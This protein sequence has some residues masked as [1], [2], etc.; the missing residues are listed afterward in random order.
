MPGPGDQCAA[1]IRKI[2]RAGLNACAA[3]VKA[4]KPN[5]NTERDLAAIRKAA[6][7]GYKTAGVLLGVHH[8]TIYK[9]V[10]TYAGVADEILRKGDQH[11]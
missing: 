7:H 6:T 10:R 5:A 11:A 2:S 8:S 3:A 1:L 4:A 9:I